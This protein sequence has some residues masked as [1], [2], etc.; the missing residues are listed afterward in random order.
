MIYLKWNMHHF[1]YLSFVLEAGYSSKKNVSL[2]LVTQPGNP[3]IKVTARDEVQ[4]RL[5]RWDAH[6][7]EADGSVFTHFPKRRNHVLRHAHSGAVLNSLGFCSPVHAEPRQS[8]MLESLAGWAALQTVCVHLQLFLLTYCPYFCTSSQSGW[9]LFIDLKDLTA[10]SRC[11]I[12]IVFS[13]YTI[14]CQSLPYLLI[15]TSLRV[16]F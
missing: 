1:Q 2:E 4:N 9:L 11:H 13:C 15:L 10:T 5:T 8:Q 3:D 12:F 7:G 6:P 16:A 14:L